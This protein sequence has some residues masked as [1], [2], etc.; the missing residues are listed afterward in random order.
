MRQTC[1]PK[2]HNCPVSRGNSSWISRRNYTDEQHHLGCGAAC[3]FLSS[4]NGFKRQPT[5]AS[6][7]LPAPSFAVLPALSKRSRI[8]LSR[9]FAPG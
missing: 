5:A 2:S 1:Q 4:P 8:Q 9:S 7:P 6:N 3:S